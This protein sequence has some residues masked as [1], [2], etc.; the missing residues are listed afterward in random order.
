MVA[1][2]M[3]SAWAAVVLRAFRSCWWRAPRGRA[4]RLPHGPRRFSN[5]AVASTS[6]LLIVCVVSRSI[7]LTGAVG[8]MLAVSHRRARLRVRSARRVAVIRALPDTLDLFM[9]GADA[10]LTPVDALGAVARWAPPPFAA[11][12]DAVGTR[13]RVGDCFSDA[14]DVLV[15]T[16]GEPARP[17]VGVLRAAD[18][19]GAALGPALRK[20]AAGAR[21]DRRRHTELAARRLP[22]A[23][24]FPLALCIL[25][26]L[27]LLTLAPVV[28]G[29]LHTLSL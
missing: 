6:A 18:R 19:D 4:P 15:E 13:Q 24:L 2:I 25:P 12:L 1:V 27:A 21:D 29:L 11:A 17:L 26:A 10:G 8:A 7:V 23:L 3:A 5:R 20:L 28:S 14:L 16:L 9:V 22:V